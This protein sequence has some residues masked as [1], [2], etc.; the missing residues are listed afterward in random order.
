MNVITKILISSFFILASCSEDIYN[1]ADTNIVIEGWIC[2]DQNPMVYITKSVSVSEA[3]AKYKTIGDYIL[4]TD[5]EVFISCEGI[6]YPLSLHK[7]STKLLPYF[8]TCEGL[9]GQ[10]NKTYILHVKWNNFNIE[11]ETEVPTSRKIVSLSSKKNKNS[12]NYFLYCT[13]QSPLPNDY[14]YV[15]VKIEG[16]D[17]EYIL[18]PTTGCEGQ[19]KDDSFRTIQIPRPVHQYLKENYSHYNPNE[20]VSIRYSIMNQS[21]F[22]LWQDYEERL[23][24]S[25]NPLFPMRTNLQSLG[26][27][28]IGYWAGYACSYD[29][30]MIK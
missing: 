11:S 4:V 12:S 26:S 6:D 16:I 5:A 17:H 8:Y 7:D 27:H 28:C 30:I 15:F 22:D 2:Q 1:N 23:D 25:R 3:Y 9:C 14:G 19:T 10:E 13:I 18:A 21:I 24:L 20:Q 29:S